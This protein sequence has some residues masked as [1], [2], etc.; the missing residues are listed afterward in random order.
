MDDYIKILFIIM[1]LLICI[2]TLGKYDSINSIMTVFILL[3]I[4]NYYIIYQY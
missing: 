2:F 4:A 1:I 3:V